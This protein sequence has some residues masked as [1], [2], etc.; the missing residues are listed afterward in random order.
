VFDET[1]NEE[2]NYS[3]N[4]LAS[5]A[6]EKLLPAANDMVLRRFMEAFGQNL[7]SICSDPYGS[8][9]LEKLL[10]IVSQRG[11]VS[12]YYIISSFY[13]Q[14]NILGQFL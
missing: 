3:C 11:L 7:R 8:H 9:V 5:A 12:M 4:Q 6:L 1:I 10:L 2:V 14:T 13:L